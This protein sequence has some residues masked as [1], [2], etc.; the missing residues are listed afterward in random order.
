MVKRDLFT[1]NIEL[2]LFILKEEVEIFYELLCLIP[3][4]FVL[5]GRALSSLDSSKYFK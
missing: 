1:F 5:L 3:I 4:N 2:T